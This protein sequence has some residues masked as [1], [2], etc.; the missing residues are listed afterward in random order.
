MEKPKYIELTIN[1]NRAD[2]VI[3]RP[4]RHNV[5]NPEVIQ[6]IRNALMQISQNDEIL[7]LVISGKGKSFCAGADINWFAGA[8]EKAMNENR[9]EFL[10][11]PEMLNIL[12]KLPQ[13]TIAAVHGNVLGGANGIIS[14]CDFVIA[15]Q[16]TEFAFGEIKLGIIPATIMPFV[17]KRLSVQDMKSTMFSGRRFFTGEALKMKLIDYEAGKDNKMEETALFINSLDASSPG[18]L[19]ACK[20]LINDIDSKNITTNNSEYTAELLAKLVHSD[21]GRE[22]LQA[23]L[24]KRKPVWYKQNLTRHS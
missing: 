12:R 16:N 3:N 21:E 4:E 2:L 17:A 23:F 10:Q 11:I 18:A 5:L 1:G 15:E 20:Q 22:G 13:I 19:K 7:F 8:G 6:E 24:E 9:R 14:A